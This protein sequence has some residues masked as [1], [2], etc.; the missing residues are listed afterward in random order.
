MYGKIKLISAIKK[1]KKLK[2]QIKFDSSKYKLTTKQIRWKKILI[3]KIKNFNI[4]K[5]KT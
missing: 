1:T 4:N 2:D 5:E 3:D